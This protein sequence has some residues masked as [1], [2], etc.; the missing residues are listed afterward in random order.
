MLQRAPGR[1]GVPGAAAQARLIPPARRCEEMPM[2]LHRKIRPLLLCAA[3]GVA[4]AQAPG[5]GASTTKRVVLKD[6]AITPATVRITHGSR[7]T[8]L[9]RD[10]TVAH[11]VTSRGTKRF[12]SSI[13]KND[14]TYTVRFTRTGTY[15][16]LCTIHPS[17]RGKIV[18]G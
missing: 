6:I 8:W 5:A 12:R 14:G 16:Y 10:D 7:I 18:V 4:A 2:N 1:G 17:M 9:W 3:V 13:S 11:N 15:R